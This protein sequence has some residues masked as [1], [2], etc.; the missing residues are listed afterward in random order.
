MF[1]LG[2][3]KNNKINMGAKLRE[4]MQ[5]AEKNL[6][7]KLHLV[8][9]EDYIQYTPLCYSSD[10]FYFRDLMGHYHRYDCLSVHRLICIDGEWKIYAQST[11][12][13]QGNVNLMPLE[14]YLCK[15]LPGLA[16]AWQELY[17]KESR[18][19][20]LHLPDVVYN[21]QTDEI[22][23]EFNNIPIKELYIFSCGA[24]PEYQEYVKRVLAN[25][26]ISGKAKDSAYNLTGDEKTT[27]WAEETYM[28]HA[29]EIDAELKKIHETLVESVKE[30]NKKDEE[31]RKFN[32]ALHAFI[33]QAETQA[34]LSVES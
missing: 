15:V 25:C 31:T 18:L 24:V 3:I 8:H 19:Y 23:Y 27:L 11:L 16:N 17:S 14:D 22:W 21:P 1:G 6:P 20:S 26:I 4:L 5:S 33:K 12:F 30:K 7:G 32:T 2:K 13:G 10:F 29:A 28:S 9:D 34:M